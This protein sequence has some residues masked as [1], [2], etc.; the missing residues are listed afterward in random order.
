MREHT[1]HSYQHQHRPRGCAR[2]TQCS[3]AC[4]S[5]TMTLAPLP[6]AAGPAGTSPV[7][8]SPSRPGSWYP[9]QYAARGM[10]LLLGLLIGYDRALS[11]QLAGSAASSSATVMRA[12]RPMKP[13]AGYPS[14]PADA[15]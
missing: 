9:T 12:A 3:S 6:P 10:A 13:C 4:R 1:R 15:H 5:T 7:V 8:T 2:L 14:R 11:A